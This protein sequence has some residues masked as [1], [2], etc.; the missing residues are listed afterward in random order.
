MLF[1]GNIKYLI[2]NVTKCSYSTKSLEN[3]Q[4]YTEKDLFEKVNLRK[5]ILFLMPRY[6]YNKELIT[7]LK[8]FYYEIREP[9]DPDVWDLSIES[10]RKISRKKKVL[11]YQFYC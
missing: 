11:F 10:L 2:G 6:V 7:E 8:Q 5:N 1:R 3:I 4:T 9:N